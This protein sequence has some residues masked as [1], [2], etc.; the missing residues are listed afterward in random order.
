[1][2]GQPKEPPGNLALVRDFINTKDIDSGTDALDDPAA[3]AEW[4]GERRLSDTRGPADRDDLDSAITFREALREF[5][6]SN[7]DGRP[8]KPAAASALDTVAARAGLVLRTR[9][10]GTVTLEAE[11]DGVD[12]ALGKLLVIVYRSM[13]VGTWSRLK[14]CRSDTCKWAFYDHS[15][16]RSGHWC[17]MS[18]CGNRQKAKGYRQR[19][20]IAAGSGE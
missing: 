7:N 15:K 6:L 4:L 13:E 3:L 17:T 2:P 14:A 9:P 16:N 1:M 12:G 10:E 5:V 20:R 19:R 11:A 8:V 18:V